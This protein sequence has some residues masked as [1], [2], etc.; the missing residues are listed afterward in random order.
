MSASAA[1][2]TLARDRTIDALENTSFDCV[3]IGGGITGAGVV[4]EATLRGLSVA[5]LEAEDFAC[6]TSSRSSKLIHGGLRY[7]AM[8]DVALVRE[9]ALERKEIFRLAPHLAERR[10]M[11]VPASSRATLLKLRMGIGTYEKLGAVDERD[12]HQNWSDDELEEQEPLLDRQRYPYACTYREYLTDD[13]RLVLANLRGAVKRGAVVLNHARVDAIPREQGRAAGVEAVCGLSGRRFRVRAGAVINAAGPWV[14]AIRRLEDGQAVPLLVLSKG[15]HIVLPR[16]R[17][18][19]R[20]M[21]VLRTRDSRSIFA[22]P[23]ARIVFV[24]TTDTFHAE[25]AEVWPEVTLEEVEYLLE[26]LPRYFALE[27]LK[28]EEIMA[29][30]AGLR[31]L[32]GEPGK[33][34]TEISRRHEV[35]VGPARVVSVAGGKLTGYRPMAR[36]AIA[37][38]A[39]ILGRELDDRAEEEPLPGG[40]FDGAIEPLAASLARE[41]GLSEEVGLR[42]TRLYG[43]E[44][45]AVAACGSGPI[46][47]GTSVLAGEVDW[48]VEQDGATGVED[49]LYRRTR[50]VIYEPRERDDLVRPVAERVSRL[51]NWSPERTEE[52][53]AGVRARLDSEFAFSGPEE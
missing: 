39:Q 26:P 21:V 51:L 6:G 20:N 46:A 8:G 52:E 40:D 9:T 19:L 36:R 28:L 5:L 16:E 32:I 30:W 33:K 18:P 37:E 7:L 25:G 48:A 35:L 42:M 22:I 53:V 27:P 4:R 24:G 41:Y 10:W 44:S 15:I 11:V 3:V 13:A 1:I 45:R 47:S 34:T 2:S 49:V 17:L 31:P 23:R 14:E 29:T 43:T 38:A 12:R 50:S